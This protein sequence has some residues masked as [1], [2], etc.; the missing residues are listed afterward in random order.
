MSGESSEKRHEKLK[1]VLEDR[2]LEYL[3]SLGPDDI[4]TLERDDGTYN[5]IK[6][7]ILPKGTMLRF[8]SRQP[9]RALE[10]RPIWADY[11]HLLGKKSFLDQDEDYSKGMEYYFGK[12]MN[13]IELK[14][15]L[16]I[17]H[18]PVNYNKVQAPILHS[19]SL[20]R[21]RRFRSSSARTM[22]IRPRNMNVTSEMEGM[23]RTLCVPFIRERH[24]K[25]FAKYA[26]Y[27]GICRDGYTLDFFYRFMAPGSKF[28]KRIKERLFPKMEGWREICITNVT[29]ATVRLVTSIYQPVP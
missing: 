11:S 23:V 4:P 19:N 2:F 16:T 20:N 18:M 27:A 12:Y 7:T 1:K 26:P 25:I 21:T 13:I 14:R 15:D 8:R 17:L 24:P 9:V 29:P 5:R 22:R 6:Y 3:D 28:F 10:N